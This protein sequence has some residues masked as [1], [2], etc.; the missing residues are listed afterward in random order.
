MGFLVFIIISFDLKKH[1]Q[2][3][4]KKYSQK[5]ILSEYQ[6]TF[7][8]GISVF[9]FTIY[10]QLSN[11]LLPLLET[12]KIVATF[13]VIFIY[14][15]II[16]TLLNIVF[17]QIILP[18]M[19]RTY[20]DHRTSY[21]IAL[22][23]YKLIFTACGIFL[24]A[25]SLSLFYLSDI[26]LFQP[27]VMKYPLLLEGISYVSVGILSRYIATVYSGNMNVIGKISLKIKVQIIVTIVSLVLTYFLILNYSFLGACVA[28][29]STE[30][31]LL[32]GYLFA[33]GLSVK[34]T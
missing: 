13:G 27:I 12:E 21:D 17:N 33:G 24:F 2:K 26:V 32:T 20:K 4:T 14:L 23:R 11:I 25:L 6:K 15:G 9:L 30:T 1:F 3:L 19:Y 8:F 31:L 7:A 29:S 28:Y 5:H 34:K 18:N 22:Q 10:Y 16:Y